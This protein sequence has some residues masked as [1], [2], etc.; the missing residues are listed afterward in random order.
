M[1]VRDRYAINQDISIHYL[2]SNDYS[3]NLTPLVYV[4]GALGFA[5]QFE[6]EMRILSPRHCLSLSL[7]GNGKSDAPLKGYT[8][9][10]RKCY[11]KVQESF[12]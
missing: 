3:P 9:E 4:P 10:K 8:L 11:R 5:E 12:E 7:R 1:P 2:E 6:D